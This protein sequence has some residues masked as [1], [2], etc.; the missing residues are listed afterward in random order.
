MGDIRAQ[1]VYAQRLRFK[2]GALKHAAI[3]AIGQIIRAAVLLITAGDRNTI[4]A[5]DKL[6]LVI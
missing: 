1:E 4:A 3:S 6:K 5:G 2:T